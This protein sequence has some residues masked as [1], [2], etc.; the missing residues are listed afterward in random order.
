[1]VTHR[2]SEV[3]ALQQADRAGSAWVISD[4]G[5]LMTA[6]YS[7]QYYND[8]SLLPFALEWTAQS[9]AVVWCQDDFPWQPDPQRDGEHAR[10]T[11][12]Q[13][14][15]AIFAEH[16][17]LPLLAV[18]GSLDERVATVATAVVRASGGPPT[19]QGQSD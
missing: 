3:T 19:P 9:R 11:S 14:L 18:H 16:P 2:E 8:A 7:L 5:P 10:T 15:A 17:L 12:Q 13:I 1:M 4:G 6:M